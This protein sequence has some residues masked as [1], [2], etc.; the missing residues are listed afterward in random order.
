MQISFMSIKNDEQTGGIIIKQSTF[1]GSFQFKKLL[2]L[3]QLKYY[4]ILLI[5]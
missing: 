3:P 4:V 5:N 2:N 1:A